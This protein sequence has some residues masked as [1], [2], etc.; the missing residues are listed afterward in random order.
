MLFLSLLTEQFLILVPFLPALPWRR[1]WDRKGQNDKG[2]RGRAVCV[3]Y[4]QLSLVK[5]Y[6]EQSCLSISLTDAPHKEGETKSGHLVVNVM[7]VF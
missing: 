1:G 4:S 3:N 2:R 7:C 6:V 5:A